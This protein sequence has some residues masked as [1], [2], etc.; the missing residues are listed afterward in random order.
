MLYSVPFFEN[1]PAYEVM[2]IHM[3]KQA[4]PQMTI[5]C[6][7]EKMGFAYEITETKINTLIIINIYCFRID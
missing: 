1:L 4:G 6:G 3:V 2:F 7:A 5:Y